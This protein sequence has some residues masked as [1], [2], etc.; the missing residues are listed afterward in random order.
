MAHKGQLL[1]V[2]S[3]HYVWPGHQTQ[4]VD[5]FT[6]FFH[7]QSQWPLPLIFNHENI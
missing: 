4:V 3:F 6:R 2:G 1:S 7:L 5:L